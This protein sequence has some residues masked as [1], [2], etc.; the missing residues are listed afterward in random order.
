FFFKL[1]TA[2]QH[3]HSFPTRRSSDLNSAS[4][5]NINSSL[6]SSIKIL[7]KL[8]ANELYEVPSITSL[9]INYIPLPD[10]AINYQAVNI[11]KDSV[12]AGENVEL[13]FAVMN[14]SSTSA[15]SFRILV[16]ILNQNNERET[17]SD[18][19][20]DNINSREKKYFNT[21]VNTLELSGENNFI[22]SVDFDNH[23]E[24]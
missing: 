18:F 23:I 7:A 19:I 21:A 4:L 9:G 13:N 14:V 8:Y 3:L 1:S 20:V 10:I 5:E 2:H 12:S 24:E 15:D 17:V 22:I 6:Y 16:E 11:D